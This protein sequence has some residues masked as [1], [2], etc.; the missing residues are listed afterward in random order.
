ML[1]QVLPLLALPLAIMLVMKVVVGKTITIKELV[2]GESGMV[3]LIV[4]AFAGAR[5][6]SMHDTEALLGRVSAKDHYDRSC[7]HSYDCPPCSTCTRDDGSTYECR[8]AT[9]YRHNRDYYWDLRFD[10]GVKLDDYGKPSGRYSDKVQV[11]T[12]GDCRGRKVPVWVK[13]NGLWRLARFVAPPDDPSDTDGK[14]KSRADD[15][16]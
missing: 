16:A 9:C 3:V 12:C 15:W 14:P 1:A 5:A 13:I 7:S 11:E 2:A 8:C 4:L 10:M 6:Y